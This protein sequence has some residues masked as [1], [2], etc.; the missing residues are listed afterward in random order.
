MASDTLDSNNGFRLA[1]AGIPLPSDRVFDGKDITA[2]LEGTSPS[3]H[4]FLFF[5]R[6]F[7]VPVASG[8]LPLGDGASTT[9]INAT[10]PYVN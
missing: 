4:T 5:Y 3:P 1:V 6:Q 7:N 10:R 8:V 2:V 9:T